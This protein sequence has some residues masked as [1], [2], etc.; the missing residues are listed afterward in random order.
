MANFAFVFPKFSNGGNNC[1][2]GELFLRN[3]WPAEVCSVYHKLTL[4]YDQDLNLCRILN[5]SNKVMH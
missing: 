5:R 3:N 2:D 4:N 1:Y